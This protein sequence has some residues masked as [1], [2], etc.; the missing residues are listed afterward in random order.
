MFLVDISKTKR[1]NILYSLG[2]QQF[3]WF[4]YDVTDKKVGWEIMCHSSFIFFMLAMVVLV[5]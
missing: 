4:M 5:I 3:L 1:S 2:M